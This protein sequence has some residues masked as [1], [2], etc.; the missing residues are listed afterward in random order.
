M[1][2][3]PIQGLPFASRSVSKAPGCG[4]CWDTLALLFFQ[5]GHILNALEAQQ[6]AVNLLA[7]DAS[8]DV[9]VRLRRYRA[10]AAAIG[11]ESPYR[12]ARGVP[13]ATR[14]RRGLTWSRTAADVARP[15]GE[16]RRRSWA[17]PCATPR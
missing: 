1:R 13:R 8:P 3:E 10:A 6:R 7:E 17:R 5:A 14:N 4:N 2:Q 12:G 15:P 9:L 16:P 11:T